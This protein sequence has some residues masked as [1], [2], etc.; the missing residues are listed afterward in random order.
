MSPCLMCC[1]CGV[2]PVPGAR[3][4]TRSRTGDCHQQTQAQV[5]VP[6]TGFAVTAKRCT[7]VPGVEVPTPP[8][9]DA[10][11]ARTGAYGVF[12][13][14]TRVPLRMPVLTPLPHVPV[15]IVQAPCIC[16]LLP[17][18]MRRPR[19]VLLVP[20]HLVQV[21]LGV[22]GTKSRLRPRTARI[23]PL[24]FGD[25][26]QTLEVPQRQGRAVTLR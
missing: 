16:L 22:S 19:S 12:H 20:P 11:R 24:C 2:A 1:A 23:F 13:V 7:A 14:S 8:A 15:Y 25:H 10:V 4:P 17:P 18:R 6:M 26:G 5:D 3:S 21:A 9:I